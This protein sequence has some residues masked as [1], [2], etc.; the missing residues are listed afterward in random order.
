[1]TA[2]GTFFNPVVNATLP[3]LLDEDDLLAANSVSWST[4]RF[5]Q[6]IG[7]ALALGVIQ[8]VG[9]EAAF[10]FNALTFFISALLLLL[11]SIPSG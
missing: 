7:S 2:A 3:T 6:I 10:V 5:V 11:L 4:G 8:I 1:M 9:A